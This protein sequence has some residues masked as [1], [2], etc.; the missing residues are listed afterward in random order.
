VRGCRG[1]DR[2]AVTVASTNTYE[3]DQNGNTRAPDASAGVTCRV[4]EGVTYIQS[5]NAEN[6]LSVVTKLLEGTCAAP[7]KTDMQWDFTYDGD[8]TRVQ[9]VVS[10]Y[11]NQTPQTITGIATTGYFM[12]G[13][14]EERVETSTVRKYYAISGMTVAMRDADGLKYLLTDHL[15]SVAAITDDD[16]TL[17]AQQRYLPFGGVRH[18]TAPEKLIPNSPVTQTDFGY[19]GQRDLEGMGLMDYNARFYDSNIGRFIQPDSIIP[20]PADP[21]SWNRFAYV[22]NNP[23]RYSDPSGHWVDEGCGSGSGCVLPPK[24]PRERDTD[25]DGDGI[26]DEPDPSQP[27]IVA[28][29]GVQ[30]DCLPG[31]L[32]ECFYGG[33]V[34]PTPPGGYY[35]V[36]SAELRSL[37]LAISYDIDNRGAISNYFDRSWY[38]TPFYDLGGQIKPGG[39]TGSICLDNGSCLKRQALNYIAQGEYSAAALESKAGMVA[40]VAGWK[41]SEYGEKPSLG[42]LLSANS[43]FEFYE[44]RHPAQ[45]AVMHTGIYNYISMGLGYVDYLRSK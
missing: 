31:N 13:L 41:A 45:A 24:N 15:G 10:T 2:N 6:R 22:L 38:D 30:A 11:D 37:M 23:I 29:R 1:D 44:S 33:G 3:Y 25:T 43:G 8:G 39:V 16:G 12:S 36:S 40:V 20:S 42:A 9:Q 5:Y 28:G 26:P 27:P 34:M 18:D 7:V 21:Q 14:Y 17:L 4:E 35:A 19:T 32:V